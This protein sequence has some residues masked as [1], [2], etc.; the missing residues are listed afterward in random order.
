MRSTFKFGA[1]VRFARRPRTGLVPG[2]H[3]ATLST[4]AGA[5]R[6]QLAAI[7][8]AQRGVETA[9]LAAE[10]LVTAGFAVCPPDRLASASAS[11]PVIGGPGSDRVWIAGRGWQT[12]NIRQHICSGDVIAAS[13][14][15]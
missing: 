12:N 11:V 9:E 13:F 1:A 8:R 4:S 6:P 2:P 15:P 5:A 7:T 10:L 14:V 3:Q